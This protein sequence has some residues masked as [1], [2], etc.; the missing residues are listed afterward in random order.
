MPHCLASTAGFTLADPQLSP[1]VGRA[2]VLESG[3]AVV[4][5][6]IITPSLAQITRVAAFPG[7]TGGAPR[8]HT[9]EDARFRGSVHRSPDHRDHTIHDDVRA[10]AMALCRQRGGDRIY[11]IRTYA[12]EA[13][14]DL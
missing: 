6:A 10:W 2:M 12:T 1:V 13:R 7:Y 14:D 4:A 5:C 3:G 11:A 8:A 9:R